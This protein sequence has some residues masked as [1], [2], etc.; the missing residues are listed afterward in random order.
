M[1][2][3]VSFDAAVRGQ[4]G[5]SRAY[6]TGNLP[7]ADAWRLQRVD[8]LLSLLQEHIHC[9]HCLDELVVRIIERGDGLTG[10]ERL[11]RRVVRET[12]Q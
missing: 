3:V 6:P 2:N 7:Y 12:R 4:S 8:R 10:L 5:R 11:A 9:P 1:N